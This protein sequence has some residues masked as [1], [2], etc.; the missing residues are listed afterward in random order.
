MKKH[1]ITVLSS[2]ALGVLMS[3]SHSVKPVALASNTNPADE[4]S[5]QSALIDKAYTAQVDVL[6]PDQFNDALRYLRE[7]KEEKTDG[8]P[9]KEILENISY[10]RAY[11]QKATKEAESARQQ[12]SQIIMARKKAI[13]AGARSFPQMLAKVDKKLIGFTDAS[14]ISIPMAERNALQD[15]YSALELHSIVQA[16]LGPAKESLRAAQED[17]AEVITPKAYKEAM[18]KVTIAEKFI[19][20]DRHSS[21]QIRKLSLEATT[22]ANRVISLLRSEK[23]SRNQSPEQRAVNLEKKNIALAESK[24]ATAEVVEESLR[25]DDE[26]AHQNN[27]LTEKT[28]SL[29]LATKQNSEFKAKA[30]DELAVRTAAARFSTDEADVYRQD[31]VLIIRL[32]SMNFATSSSELPSRSL[33]VLAKVKEVI[34]GFGP[35]KVT[36]E[37]HTDS[38]GQATRNQKLSEQ[39]AQSVAKYFSSDDTLM[40]Y[41]I[42]SL[43]FGYTKPLGTNK[44]SAGRSQNRRVDI[45]IKP[46]QSI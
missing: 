23:V 42:N 36:V 16:N 11:L 38:M 22:A 25:K 32:K 34:M 45:L 4:I 26:I 21:E 2:A 13:L 44:T 18:N 40:N 9:S 10:S 33:D 7:A 31:G 30:I 43:G 28:E 17:D 3:C 19:E 8:A 37:G 6:A 41:E 1:V 15:E 27:I 20:T 46:N 35:G 14:K 24:N 5:A 29:T 39:R 12:T